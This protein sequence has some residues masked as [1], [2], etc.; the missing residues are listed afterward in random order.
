MARFKSLGITSVIS[1]G[2]FA[3]AGCVGSPG[4][5]LF[6]GTSASSM[7]TGGIGA[8]GM[9]AVGGVASWAALSAL[10]AWVVW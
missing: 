6:G 7:G 3:L 2:A 9:S 1:L 8:G 10:A 4:E 5:E